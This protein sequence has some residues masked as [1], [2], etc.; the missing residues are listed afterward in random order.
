ME[1]S[2]KPGKF[3]YNCLETYFPPEPFCSADG[4]GMKEVSM[5]HSCDLWKPVR[6]W[7]KIICWFQVVVKQ[8]VLRT[9]HVLRG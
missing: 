3:C 4:K 5:Y 6:L 9:I 8:N 7:H 1:T 2:L